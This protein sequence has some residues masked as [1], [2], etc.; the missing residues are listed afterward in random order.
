M[1]AVTPFAIAAVVLA[2]SGVA[3]AVPA[4]VAPPG[5]IAT[6]IIPGAVNYTATNNE[7]SAIITT[8]AGTL[9]VQDG[10]FEIRSASGELVGGTPL[11][12]NVE[13]IAIPFDADIQGNTATLRPAMD[14]AYFKPAASAPQEIASKT[15]EDR[16]YEAWKKFGSRLSPGVA[17]G[18]LV[19]TI[20][21]ATVGC[22]LG[23]VLGGAV[24]MPIA[25]L[26]GGGPVAGCIAG[27]VLLA[28]VGTIA[29]ALLVG[30]PVAIAA[31]IEYWDGINRP[32]APPE[33]GGPAA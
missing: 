1:A 29:G 11:E 23:G 17:V 30:V 9:A 22:V 33:A 21:S 14:R 28:P 10:K 15:P 13:D 8:D 2:G 4:P 7:S 6:Q 31:G 18:A 19:G 26:L 5:G 16:E 27:A 32:L 3:N 20:G 25:M 24:T 12:V